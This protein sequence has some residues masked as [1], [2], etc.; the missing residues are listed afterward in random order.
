MQLCKD[1]LIRDL[2]S[3]DW[4]VVLTIAHRI[5][6]PNRVPELNRPDDIKWATSTVNGS[7]GHFNDCSGKLIEITLIR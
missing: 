6:G 3:M 4:H 2:Q 1:L 7:P 5:R